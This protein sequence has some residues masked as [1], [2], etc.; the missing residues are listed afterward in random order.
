MV[1]FSWLLGQCTDCETKNEY[2]RSCQELSRFLTV[3]ETNDILHDDCIHA[4]AELQDNLRSKESKLAGYWRKG[5]KNCKDTCTTS[6]VESNNRAVKHGP[7]GIN[8][9]MNLDKAT[10][11]LVNRIST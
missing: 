7:S 1:I 11:R 9:N 4:I 2:D 6:P 5:I 8:S 3:K 10:S